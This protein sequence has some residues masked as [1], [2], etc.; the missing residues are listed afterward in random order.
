MDSKPIIPP[1]AQLSLACAKNLSA[2]PPPSA[3]HQTTYQTHHNSYYNNYSTS[4]CP[5]SSRS[6][7]DPS[8]STFPTQK[9][10]N[11]VAGYVLSGSALFDRIGSGR[12]K[13]DGEE[14]LPNPKRQRSTTSFSEFD[15]RTFEK[16]S[17][18]VLASS[19]HAIS[20]DD[21][22]HRAV[23]G[24]P[25]EPDNANAL[26][27]IV[28]REEQAQSTPSAND[29]LAPTRPVAVEEDH[30]NHDSTADSE[31]THENSSSYKPTD[32]NSNPVR[33][34]P[35]IIVREPRNDSAQLDRQF[36]HS[37]SVPTTQLSVQP[38]ASS[39]APSFATL[40]PKHV[41]TA[42]PLESPLSLSSQHPHS[43]LSAHPA[44]YMSALPSP[45]TPA[46]GHHSHH[47][48]H[49][50]SSYPGSPTMTMT[51]PNSATYSTTA[52]T[53]SFAP[54]SPPLPQG[55]PSPVY[56]N[57]ASAFPHHATAHLVGSSYPTSGVVQG[58]N[59]GITQASRPLVSQS[60]P[61]PSPTVPKSE[62]GQWS[63]T[64]GQPPRRR[65]KLPQ[66][67]TALLRTWLMGHTSHPYPTEEEKKALCEQTGLTMN[68]VSNWFINARRRILVPPTG[69][70]SIHEVRQPVRRQAQSQLARAAANA[71][72]SVTGIPTHGI[73]HSPS[74][75]SPTFPTGSFEFRYPHFG[76][77]STSGGSARQPSSPLPGHYPSYPQPY[78]LPPSSS[79]TTPHYDASPY[80]T[81]A[82]YHAPLPSVCHH[83]AP[84]SRLHSPRSQPGTPGFPPAQV[85]YHHLAENHEVYSRPFSAQNHHS[86]Q[87][88]PSSSDMPNPMKR[89][90]QHTQAGVDR[91]GANGG[92]LGN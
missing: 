18:L 12:E 23:S 25:H 22:Y 62:D 57:S 77:R 63:T 48:L 69:C 49:H 50:R 53:T 20:T 58:V 14:N 82:A 9:S 2:S 30:N 33:V 15:G 79:P 89:E 59:A 84:P 11:S 61:V 68:Q 35:F 27:P 45:I 81:Y 1:P 51:A 10:L 5:S 28:T 92:E 17:P 24:G 38:P 34:L 90:W 19:H 85:A 6:S 67:V 32:T 13:E 73:P 29:H 78:P 91:A 46:N 83:L 86:T 4:T 36:S 52:T 60:S 31:D 66:A 75:G 42:P 21:V 65:G 87:S 39:D 71:A 72:M 3:E 70:N 88:R 8:S 7:P 64:D 37:P 74:A 56:R 76:C 41:P 54:L 55:P 40:H 26:P 80:G 16:P 47:A 44:G 43:H